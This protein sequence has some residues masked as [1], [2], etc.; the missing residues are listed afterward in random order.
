ML[1]ALDRCGLSEEELLK[2]LVNNGA[3]LQVIQGRVD[4]SHHKNP[5][6]YG[7]E[8][9]VRSVTDARPSRMLEEAAAAEELA[10]ASEPDA[11]AARGASV[12]ADSPDE[13]V[14]ADFAAAAA[15]SWQRKV[16]E[17]GIVGGVTVPTQQS[18]TVSSASTERLA[19]GEFEGEPQIGWL[20]EGQGDA[21]FRFLDQFVAVPI[22]TR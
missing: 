12:T 13:S 22:I 19:G 21:S 9:D 7:P 6:Q 14:T 17:S 8:P 1:H 20:D 3:A 10:D 4:E 18:G 5:R 2:F 11:G 15:G 16:A